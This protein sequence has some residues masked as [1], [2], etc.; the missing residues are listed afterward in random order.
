MGQEAELRTPVPDLA[1]DVQ[2]VA[3]EPGEVVE[4]RNLHDDACIESGQHCRELAPDGPGAGG[5]LS[6]LPIRQPRDA[7]RQVAA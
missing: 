5:G 1:E 4:R 2:K 6:S 3:G 7:A